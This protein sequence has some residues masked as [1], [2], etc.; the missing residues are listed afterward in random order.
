VLFPDLPD[1]PP[2]LPDLPLP[3]PDLPLLPEPLHPSS[4]SAGAVHP[5]SSSSAGAVHPSSLHPSS[6][7]LLHDLPDLPDEPPDFPDLP[8]DPPD[9]PDLPLLVEDPLHSVVVSHPPSPHPL[10][11][12]PFAGPVHPPTQAQCPPL[13]SALLLL[14]L[15]LHQPLEPLLDLLPLEPLLDLLPLEPLLEELQDLLPLE[16]L[17]P[18]PLLPEELH[19][20]AGAG[21]HQPPPLG[22]PQP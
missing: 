12:P 18:L 9:L 2:L 8:L 6:V 17:E 13:Q 11:H 4:S 16:P 3:P 20:G 5:S 14:L 19:A 7:P 10:P 21:A 22:L 15:E 1:D